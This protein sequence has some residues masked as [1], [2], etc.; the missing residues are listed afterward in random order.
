MWNVPSSSAS[1]SCWPVPTAPATRPLWPTAPAATPAAPPRSATPVIWFRLPASPTPTQVCTCVC[2][3]VSSG[4]PSGD[5]N[6]DYD[7]EPGPQLRHALRT[8]HS[9]HMTHST[10]HT[11]QC[12]YHTTH[13]AKLTAPST[14]HTL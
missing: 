1:Q 7:I 11:S 5:P 2:A 3:T 10:R 6:G 8:V 13:S 14:R 4:D 12:T 9:W